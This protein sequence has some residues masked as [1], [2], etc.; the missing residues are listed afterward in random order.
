M[1]RNR[2]SMHL[3]IIRARQQLH[4]YVSVSLVCSHVMLQS[5]KYHLFEV[6]TSPTRFAV[7]GRRR[8]VFSTQSGA[9][10]LKNIPEKLCSV[11]CQNK[12]EDSKSIT[13]LFKN[14]NLICSA[15]VL[16]VGTAFLTF[17]Q[18]SVMNSTKWL[19]LGVFN[20]AP[21]MCIVTNS[22]GPLVDNRLGACR[23]SG[24]LFRAYLQ[25]YLT[26]W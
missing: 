4:V 11:V 16:D 26:I 10:P 15:V 6:L 24:G 25:Q 9:Q 7:V 12:L 17:V 5:F 3:G 22:N 14:I 2:R 13:N 23:C 18:R 21:M 20:G 1:V 8:F 19:S